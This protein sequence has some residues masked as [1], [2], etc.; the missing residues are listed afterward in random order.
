MPS[1]KSIFGNVGLP[2]ITVSIAVGIISAIAAY[3]YFMPYWIIVERVHP[4]NAIESNLIVIPVSD[5]ELQEY[6]TLKEAINSVEQ[7]YQS[8]KN[9]IA[10]ITV[11]TKSI[12]EAQKTLDL[13]AGERLYYEENEHL[14][15]RYQGNDYYTRLVHSYD[16]PMLI[17]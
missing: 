11:K 13:L 12:S 9:R 8:D 7:R 15:L 16:R 17:E 1:S 2:I 4:Q 5:N 6:P 10:I 14:Y 3:N